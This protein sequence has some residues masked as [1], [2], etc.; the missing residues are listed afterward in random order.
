MISISDD[1]EYEVVAELCNLDDDIREAGSR[2]I[3]WKI[4]M[5][6][7]ELIE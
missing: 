3:I 1:S 5:T 6:W 7:C 2:R 4:K